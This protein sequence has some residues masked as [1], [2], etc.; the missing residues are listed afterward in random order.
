MPLE[1]LPGWPPAPPVSVTRELLLLIGFPVLMFLIIGGA[2]ML[3]PAKSSYDL[4]QERQALWVSHGDPEAVTEA[5]GGRRGLSSTEHAE[6][7]GRSAE[8][9]AGQGG[10]SARW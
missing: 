9:E 3:R 5:S 10:A 2:A 1:T 7:E 6:V 8:P 4:M